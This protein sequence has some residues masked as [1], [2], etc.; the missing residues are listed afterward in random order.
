MKIFTTADETFE[1]RLHA[2]DREVL[3]LVDATHG[4]Y[5]LAVA[6]QGGWRILDT[7]PTERALLEVHGFASRE[8]A[9]MLRNFGARIERAGIKALLT[10]R[11]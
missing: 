3:W 1:A 10:G 9:V 7:T 4:R 6:L 11:E 5:Q 8:G 2:Y